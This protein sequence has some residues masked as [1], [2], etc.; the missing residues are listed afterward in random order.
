MES[1]NDI[2]WDDEPEWDT[3]DDGIDYRTF[4]KE[5][6]DLYK[7]ELF[8]NGLDNFLPTREEWLI[9]NP[10]PFEEE[11]LHRPDGP[12][13][14]NYTKGGRMKSEEYWFLGK[15][16]A[17]KEFKDAGYNIKKHLSDLDIRNEILLR[18]ALSQ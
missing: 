2:E 5:G 12:A 16:F 7:V 4:T 9:T 3:T 11:L 14:T 8:G 17:A 18:R 6:L 15:K 1:T 13:I 10:K